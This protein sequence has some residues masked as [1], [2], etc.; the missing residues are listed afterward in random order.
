M[1]LFRCKLDDKYSSLD[2]VTA[3]YSCFIGI[4]A[5]NSSKLYLKDSNKKLTEVHKGV[6]LFLHCTCTNENIFSV[7]LKNKRGNFFVALDANNANV[8]SA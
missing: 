3:H 4:R 2:C 5:S 1:A 7:P 6:Y 8:I